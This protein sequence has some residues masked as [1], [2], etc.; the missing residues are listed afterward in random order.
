MNA[1]VSVHQKV[2]CHPVLW[3]F[4]LKER[5]RETDSAKNKFMHAAHISV[6][7]HVA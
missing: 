4:N 3:C 1:E 5:E 7:D 6:S 2:L